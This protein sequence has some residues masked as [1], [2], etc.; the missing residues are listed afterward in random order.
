[1]FRA[2]FRLAVPVVIVQVG[3]MTMGVVDTLMVGH[4]SPRDLAAVALGNLYFY[5]ISIFGVG[6]LMALDP[7]VAQG[8][9]AGDRDVIAGSMQRGLLIA[10]ALAVLSGLLLI[11]ATPVLTLFRQQPEVIPV[12]S[13]YARVLIPGM[14][15]FFA[16]IVIRQSL[17][18]M[19]R[20][21]PI[22]VATI[23]ANLANAALNWVLVFGKLGFPV[24]GAVGSGWATS[25]SRWLMAGILLG[26]SWTSLH[27]FLR[28][29][30]AEARAVRPMMR[31][32]QLGA[33]IGVQ[34]QL[35]FGA[36]AVVAILMGTLGTT[37]MA[38]HQVAL[39]LASL[40]FMVPLGIS[41]AAAVLVGQAVGRN[42]ASDARLA[43]RAALVTGVLFMAG[44]ALVMLLF[45]GAISQ[46]YTDDFPVA[47]LA[48]ALIPIAGVFQIFDGI[49]VVAAGVLRGV[50][51]TRA[52][53][54]VGLVGFWMIGLPVSVVLGF[55]TDAGPLGLWW[56]L[57]AGLAAVAAFL[58]VRVR[59]RLANDIARLRLD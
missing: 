50:G 2:L 30:R 34:H 15:P 11:P 43:G 39:S 46:L 47:H 41:A 18:A 54:I 28:P 5:T 25:L 26:L 31:L 38:A 57:V 1:V 56:G 6:L 19:G 9:G 14:L 32:I 55:H 40:T 16:F 52:P 42:S 21:A 23:V 7:V 4:V 10:V 8:V 3:M 35:E 20:V 48:A 27:A 37:E 36:F 44:S 13:Q 17:Q 33:P 29:F 58:L 12:A 53:M 51:D 22:V 24:M 45:P 59:S 49:Q